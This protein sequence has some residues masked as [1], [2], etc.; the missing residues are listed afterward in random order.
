[1][2]KMKRWALPVL[3]LIGVFCLSIAAMAAPG[4]AKS[5]IDAVLV[6][7]S[8]G[9]LDTTN[10]NL[11]PTD[12]DLIS[13]EAAKVFID[14][15]EMNGSRVGVV[16]F[17]TDIEKEVA[18]SDITSDADKQRLK[19]AIDDAKA[20]RQINGKGDTD[21]G[22]AAERAVELLKNAGNTGNEQAIV[23][24][25]DGDIN[26]DQV[27]SDE[28]QRASLVSASTQQAKGASADAADNG[29]RFYTIGLN[30]NGSL[31]DDSLISE[32]A[33]TSN[34]KLNKI[35]SAEEVPGIFFEIFAELIQSKKLE[36]A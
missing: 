3:L 26:F 24:F 25:T 12:P 18:V 11:T 7:D 6:L 4:G 34:G 2:K 33:Q 23:F 1:M 10:P 19:D 27:T 21:I 32:M 15:V 16:I 28:S 20:A 29:I 9:S 14:M 22:E 31:K 17:G 36:S 5:G 35:Q 30:S 13:F 8:S